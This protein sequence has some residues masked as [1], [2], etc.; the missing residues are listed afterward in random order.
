MSHGSEKRI[1]DQ[2][3]TV[4]LSADERTAVDTAAERAGLTPG[5]Y[6]RQ[7]LLGAP[8]P[9]QVRRPPVER[10]ELVRLLGELGKIGG[11]LNQLAKAVNSGAL[12]YGGEID[13][14]LGGLRELRKAILAALG[15]AP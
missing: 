5:S 11:N 1:R 10:R 15:R 14:E 12:V 9:R 13:A 7:T 3:L 4:R 6:A 2:H 8:A